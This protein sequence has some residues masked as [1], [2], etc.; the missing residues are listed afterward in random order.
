LLRILAGGR[1]EIAGEAL[2]GGG[3]PF[4]AL[5]GSANRSRAGPSSTQHARRDDRRGAN[6]RETRR[7]R[8]GQI[9]RASGAQLAR[10]ALAP[11]RTGYCNPTRPDAYYRW[12]NSAGGYCEPLC[13]S[14]SGDVDR[15]DP[16]RFP[17]SG[18]RRQGLFYFRGRRHAGRDQARAGDPVLPALC[19]RHH[20][21]RQRPGRRDLAIDAAY[22][23]RCSDFFA[24]RPSNSH[25]CRCS[26]TGPGRWSW[27]M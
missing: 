9:C 12:A 5:G 24:T 25:R 13:C 15:P 23:G 4:G 3:R 26:S 19:G 10:G 22:T 21:L 17:F 14:L 8:A 11:A 18:H 6:R 1:Q 16:D 7:C 20:G 2:R 27:L